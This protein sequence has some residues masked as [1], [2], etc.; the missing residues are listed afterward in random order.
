VHPQI[1]VAHKKVD[2]DATVT[3]FGQFSQNPN[4]AFW[5]HSLIFKPKIE[6]ITEQKN[7]LGIMLNA[8]QPFHKNLFARKA[9]G[10]C[11][12]AKMVVAGKV[13]FFALWD[14][15]IQRYRKRPFDCAQ[16]DI[17]S[18]IIPSKP[19]RIAAVGFL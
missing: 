16:G 7:N 15:H 5:H 17:V 14:L 10:L 13:Y 3:K 1:V 2:L 6:E 9:F 19:L 8:V 11:G 12:C 18:L 4:K